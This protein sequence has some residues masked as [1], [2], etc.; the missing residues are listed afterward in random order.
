MVPQGQE[1]GWGRVTGRAGFLPVLAQATSDHSTLL[2]NPDSEAQFISTS[3]CL[4]LPARC[5][6]DRYVHLETLSSP[7]LLP[8]SLFPPDLYCL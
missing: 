1:V 8:G 5:G 7:K 2:D 4:V 6:E 3:A